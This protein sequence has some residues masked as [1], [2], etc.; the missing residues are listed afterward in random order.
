[1]TILPLAI[2]ATTAL[3]LRWLVRKAR[4]TPEDVAPD[5]GANAGRHLPALSP[6]VRDMLPRSAAVDADTAQYQNLMPGGGMPG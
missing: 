5:K 4:V 2:L 6:D 3:T 1:M